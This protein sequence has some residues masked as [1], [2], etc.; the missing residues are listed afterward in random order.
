MVWS[1]PYTLAPVQ[2]V[3]PSQTPV[4]AT[5]GAEAAPMSA[6]ACA[7]LVQQHEAPAAA[8][9]AQRFY[10]PQVAGEGGQ[11]GREALLVADVCGE[12]RYSFVFVIF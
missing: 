10:P 3:H 1:G 2:G 8:L 11:A 5:F 6:L 12:M 7:Q 9:P 4:A